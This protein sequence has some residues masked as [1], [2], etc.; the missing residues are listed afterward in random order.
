MDRPNQTF[1]IRTTEQ[2]IS[3]WIFK[4]VMMHQ[5]FVSGNLISNVI[6]ANRSKAC[7][8]VLDT[9]SSL[10]ASHVVKNLSRFNHEPFSFQ[11]CLLHGLEWGQSDLSKDTTNTSYVTTTS[12]L[13]PRVL[14][15]ELNQWVCIIHIHL[16]TSVVEDLGQDWLSFK[17]EGI[18]ALFALKLTVMPLLLSLSGSEF[19]LVSQFV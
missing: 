8:T 7:H 11:W 16:S 9:A 3:C 17:A 15:W 13:C 10:T 2:L 18:W 12:L 4:P 5:V 6:N 14:L 1:L 19:V